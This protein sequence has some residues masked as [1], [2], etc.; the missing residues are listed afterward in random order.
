MT[1][2]EKKSY[3][4]CSDGRFY[5]RKRFEELRGMILSNANN[6]SFREYLEM[7]S[8]LRIIRSLKNKEE[9]EKL[10]EIGENN[11]ND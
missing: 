3:D 10:L 4:W 2:E 11:K 5:Y 8:E 1:P 7:E 6:D 9:Y